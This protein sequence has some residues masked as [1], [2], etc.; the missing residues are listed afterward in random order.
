MKKFI[1]I[2]LSIVLF[3]GAIN[4]PSFATADKSTLGKYY[5]FSFDENG[6]R[7]DYNA[8][9]N[10]SVQY[11]DNTFFPFWQ[12]TDLSGKNTSINYD[13]LT[14]SN[15][16]NGVD[17]LK[18][19]TDTSMYLTL[20]TKDG[21]PFEVQP[22]KDYVVRV[23]AFIETETNYSQ[24]SVMLASPN[25][26]V[27]SWY[28][29]YYNNSRAVTGYGCYG[30]FTIESLKFYDINTKYVSDVNK[31][32]SC[33]GFTLNNGNSWGSGHKG[34][35]TDTATKI[36]KTC[37]INAPDNNRY[38][39]NGFVTYNSEYNS[40]SYNFPIY[41]SSNLTPIDSNKDGQQDTV[42]LN[43][44]LTLFF[45]AATYTVDG[46]VMPFTYDIESIE[47]WENGYTPGIEMISNGEVV[48]QI[49]GEE[50]E[51]IP[52]FIPEAP[53][54]K[55]F[56][57]WY[58][59]KDCTKFI[60]SSTLLSPSVTKIYAGFND[61]NA[62]Y[63]M[64]MNKTNTSLKN[65][66]YPFDY[67]GVYS[68]YVGRY[69]YNFRKFE[70]GNASFFSVTPWGENGAF[71]LCDE[72]GDAFVAEPNAVYKISIKYKVADII[73]KD[74][75]GT[76]PDGSSYSGGYVSLAAGIGFDPKHRNGLAN[77]AFLHQT[78]SVE[79]REVTDWLTA[80]FTVDT[81]AL[82]GTLPVI[83]FFVSTAGVP[84]RYTSDGN[85]IN[86]QPGNLNFGYN[87]LLVAEVT[88]KKCPHITFRDNFGNIIA[89]KTYDFN[90]RIDFSTIVSKNEDYIFENGVGYTVSD[91]KW[92]SDDTFENALDTEN[93]TAVADKNYYVNIT[94]LSEIKGDLISYYGFEDIQVPLQNFSYTNGYSSK[95]AL[96]ASGE[97][98]AINI[99]RGAKNLN[100]T[101]DY[102]VT[103]YYKATE[104]TQITL[105]N[106]QITLNP[107]NEW[108]EV[109]VVTNSINNEIPLI[110]KSGKVTFDVFMVYQT[111]SLIGAS[112]LT[113]EAE[114]IENS[115]AIRVFGSYKND[116]QIKERGIVIKG[117]NN[118]SMLTKD[119]L[120]ATV[121]SI[122]DSF[123][124]C[125]EINGN[126][127]IF[128]YYVKDFNLQDN[129]CIT[130]RTY[131]IDVEDNIY[132]S[133]QKYYSVD[134]IKTYYNLT[135]NPQSYSFSESNT[136][137]L[138]NIQA[139][140][141][142]LSTGI[143]FD[144]SGS[145][146]E[147]NA[148]CVGDVTFTMHIPYLADAATFAAYIDGQRIPGLL[149]P[150]EVDSFDKL[151]TVTVNVGE[152]PKVHS[153]VF[154]R[155]YE[156][157]YAKFVEI[158]SVEVN[159]HLLK[160]D[161]ND[162][163]VEFV[164]DSITC[165]WGI[166]DSNSNNF[167]ADGTQTYAY[168]ASRS[169]GVDYRIRSH[170]GSGFEYA[171]NGMNGIPYA[172]NE[173]YKRVNPFRSTTLMYAPERKADVVC[174]NL[175]TNDSSG[176]KS[177]RGVEIT[178]DMDYAVEKMKSF[179]ALVESYNPGAKIV[180][181]TGGMT[182]KYAE[183]ANRTVNELGGENAGYFTVHFPKSTS[184][185]QGHPDR[186]EHT[187]MA[188]IL[189]EFLIEKDLV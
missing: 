47:I 123:E 5:K 111:V 132:Y 120:N 83:G 3:F 17:V 137:D 99:A 177:A 159:G 115:Q 14:D 140:Y 41:T 54:G 130:A 146:V 97:T 23:N 88:V 6:D 174:I 172:W 11:K 37:Y 184:G 16:N 162:K 2:L 22:G 179:I 77:Y 87:N 180:W 183:C 116:L 4:L 166:A 136:L 71:L 187:V 144:W 65:I 142:E 61:Y 127:I 189:K 62:E 121:V 67:N 109:T 133:E 55:Y 103:F 108:N 84:S 31:A 154:S 143:T 139:A 82:E 96:T 20:M 94:P 1:S 131:V 185:D 85:K 56:T 73:T 95:V 26:R 107:V 90:E 105:G 13:T 175:G 18:I 164:G 168:L 100:D 38:S 72:K 66:A 181:I 152:L 91:Y 173:M 98:D 114:K 50:R 28:E 48:K 158:R 10:K 46:V 58:T 147:L 19:T 150:V 176:W 36:N 122:T 148:Y 52:Y 79:H 106:K 171:S 60:D 80:D 118:T 182:D 155:A 9:L 117:G 153:I 125:W 145:T 126:N 92:Y 76:L 69:G 32:V 112:V 63:K 157:Y 124:N 8:V 135:E 74:E 25:A 134:N 57:G 51:N 34:T 149:L 29:S 7:Y 128:S 161:A 167:I 49:S 43:N 53:E 110:V 163:L 21:K 86:E 33:V 42:T 59:D 40:Y 68:S 15:G 160:K 75:V 102:K 78:P 170:S 27:S 138:V 188:N 89:K 151:Y 44:Y 119:S 39:D 104:E 186:T 81:G 24:A 12:Y 129:R 45:S 141:S 30:G 101:K 113:S 35:T 156:A 169:L 70:N 64:E 93:I 165:G 178:E